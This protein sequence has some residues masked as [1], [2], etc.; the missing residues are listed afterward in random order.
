MTEETNRT[1]YNE[2]RAMLQPGEQL[3]WHGAPGQGLH[4]QKQDWFVIPF[5]ILWCCFAIFWEV[6]VIVGGAPGFFVLWGIP[7]VATGLYITLGRFFRDAYRRKRTYYGVTDQR[8]ILLEPKAVKSLPYHQIPV[9]ELER[10]RNGAGTIYL[11]EQLYEYHNGRPCV[12]GKR[13]ALRFV[14]DA[15][16][17]YGIIQSKMMERR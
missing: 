7:F 6:T 9:L 12:N 10:H 4:L 11:S 5:S 16:K 3:L 14:P 15:A 2:L 1:Q 8:V 13:T 17:V